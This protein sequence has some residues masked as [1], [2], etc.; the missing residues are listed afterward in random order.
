MAFKGSKSGDLN[1]NCGNK[2]AIAACRF[3]RD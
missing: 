1:I 2:M 3:K